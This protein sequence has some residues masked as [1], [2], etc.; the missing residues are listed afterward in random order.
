MTGLTRVPLFGGSRTLTAYLLTAA[1]FTG[2]FLLSPLQIVRAD[3]PTAFPG[4]AGPA[5]LPSVGAASIYPWN[6]TVS[7][8]TGNVTKVTVTLTNI[9]H[10]TPN[11]IDIMLQ[12]PSGERA[13]IMSDT[14]GGVTAINNVTIT[15]DDAAA[16]SIPT[17]IVA[18]TYK[19]TDVDIVADNPW[20]AGAPAESGTSALTTFNGVAANGTWKLWICDDTSG[21]TGSIGGWSITVTSAAGASATTTTVA[22][23]GS[24][25]AFGSPVTFTAQ[26][27][28]SS[29]VNNG[30]VT[31]QDGASNLTCT[32]S[33]PAPVNSSGQA[34][35]TTSGLAGGNRTI[36]ATYNPGAG[37]L[38]SSGST[39]Q[40]VTTVSGS[41]FSNVG[42]II[43]EHPPDPTAQQAIPYPGEI[44]VSGLSGTITSVTLNLNG[45]SHADPTDLDMLLISPAGTPYF[46]L[47][48]VGNATGVSNVNLTIE[49]T[50]ATQ[51]PIGALLTSGTYRPTNNGAGDAIP[52]TTLGTVT[53]SGNNTAAPAG[54]GTLATAFGGSDPNGVW[55]LYIFDDS[56]GDT[57]SL[58]GGWSLTFVTNGG[59]AATT[60]TLTSGTNPSFTSAPGNNTTLTATV[61][62][63]GNPVTTG[64]VT[65]RQGATVLTCTE[66]SQPRLLNGSGQATCT[67]SFATEGQHVLTA[68]YSGTASFAISNGS[69]TQTVNNHTTA[70]PP[71]FCNTGPLT[72]PSSGPANP[73]PSLITVSGLSGTF[74]KVTATVSGISHTSVKDIDVL[75]VGPGGERVILFSDIGDNLGVVS[76]ITLTLDDAAASSLPASGAVVGGT[77]KPTDITPGDV[78]PAPAPGGATATTLGAFTASNPNGDWR[79]FVV[80]DSGGDTGTFASGVCLNFTMGTAST[81][82]TV[83]SNHNPSFNGQAVTFTATVSVTPPGVGNP[84]GSVQFKDG[85]SNLGSP[86]AVDGSGQAQLTTSSLSPGVHQITAVYS[87]TGN[88]SGSQSQP[89]AQTVSLL[90]SAGVEI[91]GRILSP[92]GRGIGRAVVTLTDSSGRVYTAETLGRGNYRFADIPA[93]ASYSLTVTQGRFRF[94]PR[95]V[96]VQDSLT[97]FDIVADSQE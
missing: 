89:L 61:T 85:A 74:S 20:P 15:L 90:T 54:T 19:P 1:L 32:G 27:S 38:T 39:L 66:G 93:G 84:T 48:D 45:L 29:T 3:G 59:A 34:T 86:V 97:N 87:P 22:S 50:A 40:Q 73:Y 70:T 5:T 52:N 43:F 8:M 96:E 92:D 67:T 82:T 91:S 21:D 88:F 57:G 80:D 28:S 55:K 36:T 12:A 35:C 33:N 47:S 71:Q 44:L 63:S 53:A 24:P 58:S 72:I 60:T 41:T 23:S 42:N 16:N 79:I 65:F 30:T 10:T 56:A 68:F 46:P 14:G 7:G 13:T 62:S 2:A 49:D 26:V 83:V 31:F 69:V 4:T 75:L 9:T 94:S 6:A 37:F 78:F 64:D 25:T 18:G 77:F 51:L 17:P 95:I 76:N 11:D 81:T